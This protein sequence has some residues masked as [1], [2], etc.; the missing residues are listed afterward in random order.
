MFG[1]RVVEGAT[2]HITQLTSKRGARHVRPN[3]LLSFFFFLLS[4]VMCYRMWLIGQLMGHDCYS[5]IKVEVLLQWVT[6]FD[7]CITSVIIIVAI[8]SLMLFCVVCFDQHST[9]LY[10]TTQ[11]SYAHIQG[12]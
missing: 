12:A 3:V 10:V 6:K 9:F 2:K 11:S 1:S 8:D 4:S 5:S 7:V